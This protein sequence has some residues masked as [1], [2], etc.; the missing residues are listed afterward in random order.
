MKVKI[1]INGLVEDKEINNV[2][3]IIDK[4]LVDKFESFKF[5]WELVKGLEK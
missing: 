2:R 5:N 1:E 4:L 3:G